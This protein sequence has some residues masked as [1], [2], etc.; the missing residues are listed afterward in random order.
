MRLLNSTLQT[1][2]SNPVIEPYILVKIDTYK[3]TDYYRSLL[4]DNGETYLA[5]GRLV[6]TD[7]PR[8]S[9][10]VD[11]EIYRVII[12]DP[13][14]LFGPTLESNLIGKTLEVRM[15]FV[16]TATRQP[17]TEILN[18]II[19]YRGM[20]ESTAYEVDLTLQG[21]TEIIITGSSPMANLDSVKTLTSTKYSMKY[22]DYNDNSFE[23]IY[24]GSGAVILKWGKA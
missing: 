21:K 8:V 6:A 17:Y 22:I 3:T 23:Q 9:A 7:P 12:S 4:M 20:I 1:I 10:T 18:T 16:N 2:L 11:R 15:G 19:V 5:D 24:E 14:F 13:S